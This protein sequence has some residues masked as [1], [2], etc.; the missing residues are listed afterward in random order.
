MACDGILNLSFFSTIVTF[1]LDDVLLLISS[2]KL[3]VGTEGSLY[4]L[5]LPK[6]LKIFVSINSFKS[7]R[8]F[9]F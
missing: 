5:Q 7:L 9:D 8:W 1:I 6:N 4:I 2:F 3:N